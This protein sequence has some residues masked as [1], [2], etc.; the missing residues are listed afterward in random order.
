MRVETWAEADRLYRAAVH[1]GRVLTRPCE[2]HWPNDILIAAGWARLEEQTGLDRDGIEAAEHNQDRQ[3]DG[4]ARS[5]EKR[6]R[7]IVGSGSRRR[8]QI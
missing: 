1:G 8:D 4:H 5:I 7:P 2:A 6:G 3:S